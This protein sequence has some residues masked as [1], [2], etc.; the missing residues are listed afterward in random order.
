M[1]K[2]KSVKQI[3]LTATVKYIDNEEDNVIH[4]YSVNH[5]VKSMKIYCE[6]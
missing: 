4:K 1:L 2:I 3:S 5:Y 6:S